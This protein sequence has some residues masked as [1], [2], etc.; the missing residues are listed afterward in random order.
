MSS[1][2]VLAGDAAMVLAMAS[3]AM[4]FARTPEAEAERWLRLL[5][6]HGDVGVA[7]QG[8]GV[9]DGPVAERGERA[10][11]DRESSVVGHEDRQR[12]GAVGHNDREQAS[13]ADRDAVAMVAE[14]AVQTAAQR[15]GA[16]IETTDIL[17]AVM[18]VYGEDFERVLRAHGTD[19][20]A[21]LARLGACEA[22]LSD[23]GGAVAGGPVHDCA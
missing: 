1:A 18:Y 14:R 7:L 15:S 3:T 5:R 11:G 4:P 8:L 9:S 20:A 22:R 10:S 6:V 23:A 21:V 16:G 13:G 12:V 2:P 17:I 19:G